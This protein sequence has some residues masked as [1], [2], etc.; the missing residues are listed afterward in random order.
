MGGFEP[1]QDG[2]MPGQRLVSRGAR[3]PGYEQG[4][5]MPRVVDLTWSC[6]TPR[7]RPGSNPGAGRPIRGDSLQASIPIWQ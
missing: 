3:L 4:G 7:A 5:R 2:M 1:R 6:L